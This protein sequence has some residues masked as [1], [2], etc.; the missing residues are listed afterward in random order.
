[1][2][3]SSKI[4]LRNGR[5]V[6]LKELAEDCLLDGELHPSIALRLMRVRELPMTAVAN[7]HGVERVDGRACLIWDFVEGRVLEELSA[8][9]RAG[10]EREVRLVVETLHS[11]GIVHGALHGRNIIVDGRGGVHVTHVSPLLHGDESVDFAALDGVF[12]AGP[13]TPHPNPLP[14]REMGPDVN[15]RAIIGAGVALAVG[16]LIVISVIWWS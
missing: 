9:E 3:G 16:L 2:S 4:V 5:R 13:F 1:V 6:V 7:L 15:A 8:T 10:V 14:Q 11:H 12:S